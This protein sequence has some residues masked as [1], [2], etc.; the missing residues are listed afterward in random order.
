MFTVPEYPGLVNELVQW[1]LAQRA[2]L[3]NSEGL[4]WS[5]AHLDGAGRLGQSLLFV[6]N[7]SYDNVELWKARPNRGGPLSA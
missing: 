1:L 4:V 5:R 3:G 6:G 2:G 7:G